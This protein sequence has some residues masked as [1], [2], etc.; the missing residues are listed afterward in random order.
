MAESYDPDDVNSLSQRVAECIAALC[1][2]VPAQQREELATRLALSE[3]AQ[4]AGVPTESGDREPA[5]APGNQVV[6]L[7][8][9]S[10]TAIVLPAGEEAP[11]AAARAAHLLSLARRHGARL[12]R[13][14]IRG[15]V[16]LRQ[17]GAALVSASQARP[18]VQ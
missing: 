10:G 1:P 5:L 9:A 12:G 15:T 18:R 4:A 13:I 6:W 17:A 2:H 11:D 14:A 8:G 7:P 3:I 16:A